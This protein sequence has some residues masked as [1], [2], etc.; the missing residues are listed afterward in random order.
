MPPKKPAT[1]SNLSAKD[2][3]LAKMP[4]YPQWPAFIMPDDLIP[5]GVLKAKKKLTNF[6]VIFIPDGDFYWMTEKSLEPLSQAKL[7]AQ[8]EKVPELFKKNPKKKKNGKPSNVNEAFVA[9]DGLDFDTFISNIFNE[10]E[11]EEE[12]EDDD[13]EEEGEEEEEDTSIKEEGED[14]EGEEED[15]EEEEEEEENGEP[16]TEAEESSQSKHRIR[17]RKTST[18]STP[19]RNGKRVKN[20]EE[21][22]PIK[23][24]KLQNNKDKKT[25]KNGNGTATTT[26]TPPESTGPRHKAKHES[27]P[28][29]E[30][31]KQHQL[32]LCRIKLQ[33]SLIQRNQPVTPKDTNGL[34][35]PTADELSVAR[36]ILYRLG[37]FPVS[38]DLLKKTKIHKVLKCILKDEALA[39]PDSFK[40][41][42]RCQELLVKWDGIVQS[43]KL[44]KARASPEN[45]KGGLESKLSSGHATQE[46]SEISALNHSI[47]E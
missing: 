19:Q 38:V 35:P 24:T 21:E 42:E 27:K 5:A 23:K 22:Q 30:E 33:R 18:S 7:E 6:C 17:A 9:T 31:E 10:D 34:K 46:E 3:V 40:L 32:W 13:E 11:D 8:L 20:E 28:L 36:L 29:T 16:T 43:L 37:D 4:R 26:T 39:Y 1:T 41:H 44:E 15:E 45:A 12:E 47:T 25:N 2:L 14:E